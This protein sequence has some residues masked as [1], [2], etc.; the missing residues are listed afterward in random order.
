[1]IFS[2]Y[3]MV[4]SHSKTFCEL[5]QSSALA[6]SNLRFQEPITDFTLHQQWSNKRGWKTTLNNLRLIIQPTIIFWMII[7]WLDIFPNRSLL[8]GFHQLIAV[9]NQF[10]FHLPDG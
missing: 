3:W 4:S 10:Y 7:P 6:N 5:N 2:A 9:M 8:I 1:M